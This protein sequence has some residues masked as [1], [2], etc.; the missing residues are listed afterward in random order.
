MFADS[1]ACVNNVHFMNKLK[2]KNISPEIA[3]KVPEK[4]D[5][6]CCGIIMSKILSRILGIEDF[7]IYE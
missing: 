5:I 2:K 6:W 3:G 7:T 1:F 4:Y